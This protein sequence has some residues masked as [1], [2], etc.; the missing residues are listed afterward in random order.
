VQI[1]AAPAAPTAT[2]AAVDQKELL[3]FCLSAFK[4]LN[5]PKLLRKSA[6]QLVP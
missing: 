3:D 4:V 1:A 2:V 6:E 5:R